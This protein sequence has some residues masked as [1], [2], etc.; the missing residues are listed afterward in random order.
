[1]FLLSLD[2]TDVPNYIVIIRS[3]IVLRIVSQCIFEHICQ[4]LLMNC[5]LVEGDV[6]AVIV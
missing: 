6:V 1:M 4:F 3:L 2:N 5:I